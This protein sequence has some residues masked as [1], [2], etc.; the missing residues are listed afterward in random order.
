MKVFVD[1]SAILAVLDKGDPFHPAGRK[2]WEF[3][4]QDERFEMLTT[5]YVILES[6]ALIQNRIGMMAAAAFQT[7][8]SPVLK[9]T[10]VD[11]ELHQAGASAL[12]TANRR[13]LSLVD[14]ISFITMRNLNIVNYFGFDKHFD[15]QGFYF[16]EGYS[17]SP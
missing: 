7:K 9:I 17:I 11:P 13:Q 8:I 6:A 12:I 10:W 1:T 4:L 14:C 16:I 3:L 15:E 5:N 2:V